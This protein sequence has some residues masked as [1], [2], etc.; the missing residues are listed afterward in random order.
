[1]LAHGFTVETLGRLV[2]D[3]LA[4]ATWDRVCRW[5][6]D[7]GDLA[8]DYRRGGGGRLRDDR[9]PWVALATAARIMLR[10][11]TEAYFV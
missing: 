7:R 10:I 9:A 11:C 8:D 6:A 3:G 1:M 4:T 2:L 5:A